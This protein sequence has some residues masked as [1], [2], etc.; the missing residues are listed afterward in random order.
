MLVYII[1]NFF[2]SI[3]RIL[4]NW[5]YLFEN[6]CVIVIEGLGYFMEKFFFFGGCWI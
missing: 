3:V 4:V 2:F 6:V 5:V 1:G